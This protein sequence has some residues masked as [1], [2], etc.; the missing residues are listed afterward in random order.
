MV[1]LYLENLL[2]NA[3]GSCNA[4]DDDYNMEE[5][6]FESQIPNENNEMNLEPCEMNS[7]HSRLAIQKL[8]QYEDL[9]EQ[10]RL[11]ELPCKVGDIAWVIDDDFKHSGKKKIYEAEWTRVALV[12]VATKCSFEIRGE[13]QYQVY[14]FFYNDGRTMSHGMY[15]GQH[16]TK[17]G[18][19]VFFTEEEAEEKLKELLNCK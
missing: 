15:V 18:E 10:G 8:A 17:V 19:V 9:E 6:N 13:V 11:L 5:P 2:K 3:G 7:H 14:D 16:N 1:E 12:Q 4:H